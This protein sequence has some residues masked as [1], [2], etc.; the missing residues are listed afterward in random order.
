MESKERSAIN[1]IKQMPDGG[2]LRG[3]IKN[4]TIA[5]RRE[6][7]DILARARLEA[8]AIVENALEEA[9]G[10]RAHAYQE[11]IE[12]ALAEFEKPL[13]EIREI[14]SNVLQSAERDLLAL[15]VR[16]AEKILGKELSSNKKAIT[17][18]VATALRN[19]RQM[20]KVTVFVNPAD[21]GTVT[22]ERDKFSSDARIRLLDFAAD[23]AVPAGGCVIETEVGR[24][25]ARLET[26]FKVIEQALLSRSDSGEI[27]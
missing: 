5:A 12:K 20:E 9:E 1:V 27:V 15:S 23:P 19:A 7:D 6:A 16:I 2:A 18:I 3:V 13:I 24:I 11:G 26:Q 4:Q 8:E 25:D 21:L 14:R 17:D 22:G 10:V